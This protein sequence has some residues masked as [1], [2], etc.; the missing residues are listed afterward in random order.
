MSSSGES[1]VLRVGP[2]HQMSGAVNHSIRKTYAT[3]D[4]NIQVYPDRSRPSAAKRQVSRTQQRL[5]IAT[6]VDVETFVIMQKNNKKSVN[7]TAN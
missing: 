1:G 4:T 5:P 7:E 2:D 3:G 6:I